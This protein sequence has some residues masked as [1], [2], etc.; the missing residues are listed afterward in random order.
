[1]TFALQMLLIVS[2]AAA[3]ALTARALPWRLGALAAAL[4]GAVGLITSFT[5]SAWLGLLASLAVLL[6]LRH[7]RALFGL[8]AVVLVAFF[9]LPGDY[10]D[11]LRST[12]D[13]AHPMNRE[14]ALMW[15]AGAHILRDHPLTGVGLI[16]L[17]PELDR[18]RS[19]E[20]VEHPRHLH[21][22]YLQVAATA[23]LIG[24]A[25]FAFLCL[26]LLRTTA[27]GLWALRR[28]QGLAAG[29]RLGVTAGATG[30]L[31]AALFD[32]A[33]G[34]EPLLFLLFS[35]AG[36]AWAAQGWRETV[37]PAPGTGSR[38]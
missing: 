7:P 37:E 34:D 25:S 14:R 6:G 11:R 15:D 24:L 2:L 30:F 5:R 22:S 23:G 20:A 4:A 21:D 12:F 27:R 36:I 29:V 18:Y 35:L 26:G 28:A 3:I 9:A 16:D 8:A 38:A 31:V 33:F 19:P 1:M 32:H 17:R 13:P 10:G